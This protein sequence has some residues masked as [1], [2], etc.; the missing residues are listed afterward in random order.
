MSKRHRESRVQAKVPKEAR[1]L[2]H[3]RDRHTAKAALL[4]SDLEAVVLPSAP[5][6][7][8]T[9]DVPKATVSPATRPRFRHWKAPFWKRRNVARHER[10]VQLDHLFR[11]V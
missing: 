6:Q 4:A 1:R 2:D 7:L 5:R 9:D 3:R 8:A 10:N 11:E